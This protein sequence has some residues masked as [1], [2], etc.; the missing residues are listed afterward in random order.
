MNKNI[1]PN[2]DCWNYNVISLASVNGYTRVIYSVKDIT[3][4]AV[5]D[6]NVVAAKD[7]NVVTTNVKR[8]IS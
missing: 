7:I 5:K 2:L 8:V 1:G 3:V 6:I 4:V